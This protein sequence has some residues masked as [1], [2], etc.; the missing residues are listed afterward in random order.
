MVFIHNLPF[1]S[2]FYI[3]FEILKFLLLFSSVLILSSPLTT[4]HP[5]TLPYPTLNQTFFS[6]SMSSSLAV[7]L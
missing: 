6:S 4:N 2:F 3:V 7:G 1:R 5:S